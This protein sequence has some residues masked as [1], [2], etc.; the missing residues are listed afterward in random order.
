MN[1]ENIEEILADEEIEE[2]I[3]EVIQ[4]ELRHNTDNIT[5]EGWTFLEEQCPM[6]IAQKIIDDEYDLDELSEDDISNILQDVIEEYEQTHA[7]I[8][9]Y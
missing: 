2:T 6:L 5:P 1:Q 4:N 9:Y 7:N 8:R 3:N